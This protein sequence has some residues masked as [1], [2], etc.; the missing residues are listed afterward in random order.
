M[1]QIMKAAMV[2]LAALI[3]PAL[4]PKAVNAQAVG[5]LDNPDI[6]IEYIP[7]P[8]FKAIY[9]RVTKRK[10]LEQI[11]QFLA[12]LKLGTL[13][14]DNRLKLTI[15]E[16]LASEPSGAINAWYSSGGPS[17]TYCYGYM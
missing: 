11:K 13:K 12:P 4:A 2:V 5:G 9:E 10:V 1:K 7:S 3:W 17:I 15:R 8:Q 16:C 14:L 6:E